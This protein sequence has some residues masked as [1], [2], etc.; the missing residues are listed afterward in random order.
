MTTL[1]TVESTQVVVNGKSFSWN[2]GIGLD[3]EA[4]KELDVYI[5]RESWRTA[6][7]FRNSGADADDLAQE[8]RLAALAAARRYDPT[9]GA[10]FLTYA[11]FSIRS[12][13]EIGTRSLVPGR[14]DGRRAVVFS[15]DCPLDQEGEGGAEVEE[16]RVEPEAFDRAEEIEK[17]HRLAALLARL[18]RRDRRVLELRLGLA[19]GPALDAE[20]VA[21]RLGLTRAQVDGCVRRAISMG[22]AQAS[23]RVA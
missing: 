18:G 22:T 12:A 7:A 13:M 11:A 1:T 14:Q 2:P 20:S 19:G 6:R 8:A 23:R 21:A 5:R 16:P 10:S 15:F 17:Q 3:P 9:R 4:V